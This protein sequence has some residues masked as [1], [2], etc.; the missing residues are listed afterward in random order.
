MYNICTNNIEKAPM[1]FTPILKQNY[2][3]TLL[4]K[5]KRKDIIQPFL[6]NGCD[7]QNKMLV[8]GNYLYALLGSVEQII[9][10]KQ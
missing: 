4:K 10:F 9:T 1:H 5:K 6:D 2:Y 7:E 8:Y 3:I